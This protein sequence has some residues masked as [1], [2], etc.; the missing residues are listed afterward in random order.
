VKAIVVFSN[1]EKVNAHPFGWMLRDNFKHC[2]IS[3]CTPHGWVEIDY[4]RGIP[5]ITVMA[6]PEFD[7]NA[8]YQDIG[9]VTVETKQPRDMKFIFNP[10]RGNIMVANCVGLVK[11]LLGIKSLSI[12]PYQLFKRLTK[13]Q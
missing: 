11:A 4:R 8:Y 10:F 7:L 13:C 12:T 2:F 9:Y 6:P 5:N 3:L 1:V